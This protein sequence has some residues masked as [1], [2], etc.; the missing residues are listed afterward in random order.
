MYCGGNLYRS[1]LGLDIPQVNVASVE[2]VEVCGD[3]HFVGLPGLPSARVSGTAFPV[4]GLPSDGPDL[5][6]FDHMDSRGPSLISETSATPTG[7]GDSEPDPPVLWDEFGLSVSESKTDTGA[8]TLH[9][10]A[11][12]SFAW[13]VFLGNLGLGSGWP[14]LGS[15]GPLEGPDVDDD[16]TNILSQT[17]AQHNGNL[18]LRVLF[19]EDICWCSQ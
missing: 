1:V 14:R 8:G 3:E 19:C 7:A 4:L 12:Y 10:C 2:G 11:R 16:I 18:L 17:I 6:N 13:H 15:G 5:W 9:V